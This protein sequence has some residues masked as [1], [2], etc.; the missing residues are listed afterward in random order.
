MRVDFILYIKNQNEAIFYSI[1]QN[2]GIFDS[3]SQNDSLFYNVIHNWAIFYINS[4]LVLQNFTT[5]RK[6]GKSILTY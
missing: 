5:A 4:L 2:D 6:S 1:I 3:A